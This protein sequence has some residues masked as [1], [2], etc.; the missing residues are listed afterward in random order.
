MLQEST[1]LAKSHP[2]DIRNECSYPMAV[3]THSSSSRHELRAGALGERTIGQASLRPDRY[4]VGPPLPSCPA[5]S[6][7]PIRPQSGRCPRSRAS[8]LHPQDREHPSP[9][10]GPARG[11]TKRPRRSTPTIHNTYSPL[12]R[13]LEAPPRHWNVGGVEIQHNGQWRAPSIRSHPSDSYLSATLV[14]H[15][16]ALL[17]MVGQSLRGCSGPL[18]FPPNS[19]NTTEVPIDETDSKWIVEPLLFASVEILS[20]LRSS[21]LPRQAAQP[22]GN[23]FSSPL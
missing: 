1:A 5:C 23:C 16:L 22:S 13:P 15:A 6:Q 2:T 21:N 14:V 10:T 20:V 3:R 9:R 18:F 11:S 12:L 19:Y 7:H 17:S 4:I 8:T